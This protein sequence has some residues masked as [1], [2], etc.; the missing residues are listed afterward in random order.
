MS[1]PRPPHLPDLAFVYLS[2]AYGADD[3]LSD[4]ELGA[5]IEKLQARAPELELAELQTVVAKA[6]ARQMEVDDVEDAL[7]R[8]AL[9]LQDELTLEE[10]ETVLDDLCEVAK[11]DGVVLHRERRLL[12]ELAQWWHLDLPVMPS[13]GL[14]VVAHHTGGWSVLHDLAFL[15]LVLAHSTDDELTVTEVQVILAKLQEWQ[16]DLAREDVQHVLDEAVER[17]ASGPDQQALSESV[18][19]LRHTLPE[20]QRMAAL[21]DLV[22][23]ANADG[24]FLDDEEDMINDLMEAWEVAAFSTYGNQGTKDVDG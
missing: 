8:A 7:E 22:Q 4:A 23:I 6:L 10:Q 18:R 15:Y 9:A 16:P 5:V 2:I 11:A 13:P 20:E 12:H 1:V 24:I 19:A 17:Y 14:D 3:Y 21:N